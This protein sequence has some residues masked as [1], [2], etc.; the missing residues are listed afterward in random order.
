[1]VIVDTKGLLCDE[2]GF[3]KKLTN[4]IIDIDRK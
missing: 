4:V 2:F 1:M 3:Y